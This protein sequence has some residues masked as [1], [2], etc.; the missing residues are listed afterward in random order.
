MYSTAA[1]CSVSLIYIIFGS[2]T[3]SVA[4]G[5]AYV[6]PYYACHRLYIPSLVLCRWSRSS[7][8]EKNSNPYIAA[9]ERGGRWTAAV[10]MLCPLVRLVSV[11]ATHEHL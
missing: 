11:S 8:P 5:P 7:S 1:V 3:A 2:A 9:A 4:Y 6:F 10:M